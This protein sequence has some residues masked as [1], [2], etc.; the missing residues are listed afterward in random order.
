MIK[1]T[2]RD[3][4]VGRDPATVTP[5]GH[6]PILETRDC[7]QPVDENDRLTLRDGTEVLVIGVDDHIYPGRS[8]S[9]PPISATCY[10]HSPKYG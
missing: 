2:I 6:G 3:G 7:A 9:R 8:G 10:S 4:R 1:V 5:D